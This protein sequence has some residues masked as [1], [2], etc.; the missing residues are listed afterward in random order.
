MYIKEFL[1]V[2]NAI[3][4]TIY[5]YIIEH[6]NDKIKKKRNGGKT[7]WYTNSYRRHLLDMHIDDWSEEFLSE[8]SPEKYFQ[9]LKKANIQNAMIY[10]QS[11][12]GLCHYPTKSGK[13]H[14]GLI[15][16]E[17]AVKRL[18][19]M[20][21]ANGI[22]VTGYYSLMFNSWAHDAHPEWRMVN[23]Q[24][25]SKRELG[26]VDELECSG[27]APWRYG[28]CCP[29]NME[30]RAFVAEQIKEMA[31]YF[32]VDGM[33][34]DM[35]YWEQFCCCDAC[36]ERWAKEVGGELPTVE[37]WNAPNWLLL[38]EKRRQWMGEFA[39]FVT[40]E[41]KKL[42]PHVT[43]E[44]NVAY[45]ALPNAKRGLA[46][47]VIAACDYAGGD[48]HRDIYSHSYICKLYRN[49]TPNQPFENMVA[50]C[51][52]TLHSHTRTKSDDVLTSAIMTTA[53]HHGA[54]LVIDAIDPVGTMDTRVYDTIGKIFA[55][56]KK[57]EK[58][59]EGDLIEDIGIYYSLR[60]KYNAHN[61][62]YCNNDAVLNTVKSMIKHNVLCGVTGTFHSLEGYQILMASELKNEDANDYGRILDYVREGGQLYL[63]GDDCHALLEEFF[64][65]TVTGRTRERTVY[66]AP[67]EKAGDSFEQFNEK[68]PLV[69]TGTAPIVEG[70]DKDKVIATIKLPYTHQDTIKCASIHSNP[71]GIA[72][73]IPAVAVTE[74]GKGK[75]IWS[76]LPIEEIDYYNYPRILLGLFKTFFV[77]NQTIKSDADVD[78]EITGFKTEEGVYVNAVLL[79]DEYYARRV[80]P[81][82][83]SVRCEYQ[84]NA[85]VHLPEENEIAFEYKD[86]YATFEIANLNIFGM[87]KVIY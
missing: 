57:Y 6:Q 73:E 76:S 27:K 78:V 58:Y 37:D 22:T 23:E 4:G 15:G 25:K 74:Y 52:P 56:H 79:N 16:K 3:F 10:F 11:H 12:V 36:K 72:T 46:E 69:F 71:P 82:T 24:G 42:M 41:T 40:G 31:E 77:L 75:V 29:N 13:M 17:D 5:E 62:T 48:V 38:V 84:P 9:N 70:I 32:D 60:S 65:A 45:A 49:L 55:E 47:E 53:A 30:Y 43:V 2:K 85:V 44:H 83:I 1:S 86:G 33:F 80:A 61:E 67:N 19:D 26:I 64:G 8:F 14:N 20:C 68:Y 87:Y 21:R 35:T 34:Y 39:Q 51:Y 59:F 54:S 18:V 50:R 66:I 81:F 7:M 63:S 28:L